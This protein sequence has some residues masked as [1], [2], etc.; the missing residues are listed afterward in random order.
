MIK[1]IKIEELFELICPYNIRNK[2]NTTLLHGD[3]QCN[4]LFISKNNDLMT[5]IDW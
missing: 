2:N 3:P 1:I 5:M 4:N